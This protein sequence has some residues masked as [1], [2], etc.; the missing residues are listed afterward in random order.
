MS[1]HLLV[2]SNDSFVLSIRI[3]LIYK[4]NAVE[5]SSSTIFASRI[6]SL[7]QK[8][9]S[10][11]KQSEAVQVNHKHGSLTVSAIIASVN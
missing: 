6:S 9:L 3:K 4:V 7:I 2:L 5:S 11:G 8:A 10:L 1:C